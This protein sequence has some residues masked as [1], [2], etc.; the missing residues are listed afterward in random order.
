VWLKVKFKKIHQNAVL[1]SYAKDGDAGL[2]LTCVDYYIEDDIITYATG[3]SIE[4]PFGFVGLIFPRS[5]IRKKSLH[6]TN[7]VGVIDSGYRGEI[8][9]SFRFSSIRGVYDVGDRIAQL[10]ILPYPKID[11]IICDDLSNSERGGGGFGSTGR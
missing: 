11:P 4:I 5:S 3:L 7:S 1:P 9:A 10:V 2:D 6:L 8:L